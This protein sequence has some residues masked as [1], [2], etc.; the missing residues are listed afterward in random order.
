[1]A[2]PKID[3][4][5]FELVLPSNNKKIKFRPFLVKEEKIL[6]MAGESKNVEDI[7]LALNQIIKNCALDELD[8]ENLPSFDSEYIFLKLREKSVGELISV[9]VLD[10][11]AQKRFDTD[12]NL[13]EVQIKKTESHTNKIKLSEK[14]FVEMKYPTLSMILNIDTKKSDA[15]NGINIMIKCL[16]KIYDSDSVYNAEDYSKKELTEF[17][18]NLSQSMFSKLNKFFETMPSLSYNA[19]VTSPYTNNTIKLKLEN[20]IDFFV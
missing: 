5:T 1:M 13:T 2:L 17:I 18:E 6:L 4:P 20:F 12:I 15:E 7:S 9:S 3:V 14:L 11:E 8:V 16:D 10:E 19:E